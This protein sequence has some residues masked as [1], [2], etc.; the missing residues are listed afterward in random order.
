VETTIMPEGPRRAG[1]L[2][3]AS[4]RGPAP[5]ATVIWLAAPLLGLCMIAGTGPGGTPQT[6]AQEG[7]YAEYEVKATLIVKLLRFATWPEFESEEEGDPVCIGVL[8]KDPFGDYLDTA[9]KGKQVDGHPVQIRRSDDVADLLQCRALFIANS[10][11]ESLE[12]I[13]RTSR[14]TPIL[15]LGDHADFARRG[16]MINLVLRDRKVSFEINYGAIRK[17]DLDLDAQL[18]K[19][20]TLVE[21]APTEVKPT[22]AIVP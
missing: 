16:V 22:S 9:I 19:L 11:S 3:A 20:A 18:L 21:T 2:R 12:S 15:T 17:A 4:A 10:E 14:D 1:G 6:F 5:W 13:L 8:G 7:D